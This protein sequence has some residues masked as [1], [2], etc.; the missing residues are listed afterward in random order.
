[1][2]VHVP[3]AGDDRLAAE[4]DDP[5][6]ARDRHL[7][8]GTNGDD[9]IALDHDCGVGNLFASDDIQH[10][11]SAKNQWL[12]IG[13][14]DGRY[15][16]REPLGPLRRNLEKS[17]AGREYVRLQEF[18]AAEDRRHI[19]GLELQTGGQP[20]EAVAPSQ[21]ADFVAAQSN[22]LL[23]SPHAF[24]AAWDDRRVLAVGYVDR[25]GFAGGKPV[26]DQRGLS[27]NRKRIRDGEGRVF[28]CGRMPVG[29]RGV[30]AQVLTGAS[31]DEWS[32]D[33]RRVDP[34]LQ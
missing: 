27:R 1:M 22:R 33:A 3:K 21:S 23:R 16:P 32:P 31:S 6:L 12:R 9:M 30:P 28:S 7:G 8:R 10:G 17:D 26:S 29:G 15:G 14:S 18:E 5:G 13:R 20:D 25:S 2:G 4:I 11:R 19:S 34:R 24:R